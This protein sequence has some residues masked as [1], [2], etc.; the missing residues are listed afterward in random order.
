MTPLK[1]A[2]GSDDEQSSKG[3]LFCSNPKCE[4]HRHSGAPG[5]IGTGN[6]A[7]LADGRIIGR[8]IY[9]NVVLCDVC[10]RAL[11]ARGDS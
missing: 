2:R 11:L 5:V 6:W 1:D 7:L 4:L 9:G 3:D 10:G 8:G